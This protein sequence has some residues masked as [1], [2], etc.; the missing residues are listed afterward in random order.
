MNAQEESHGLLGSGDLVV[1]ADPSRTPVEK[2]LLLQYRAERIGKAAREWTSL[3]R[4]L[5]QLLANPLS[6]M[7]QGAL[8]ST[9]TLDHAQA[10]SDDGQPER[11]KRFLLNALKG[12]MSDLQ[13]YTDAFCSYLPL[14]LADTIIGDVPTFHSE[15][16]QLHTDIGAL[17]EDCA[18][19]TSADLHTC[20]LRRTALSFHTNNDAIIASIECLEPA[21]KIDKLY[22]CLHASGVELDELLL[23]KSAIVF[24][25][26]SVGGSSKVIKAHLACAFDVVLID[27]AAQ[28]REAETSIV[29]AG[30]PELQRLILVGDDR[31]L[32]A[33]ILSTAAMRAQ[34]GR[35]LF[36]RLHA[37]GL[38]PH[39]LATQYR[40]HPEISRW[41]TEHIYSG[42]LED[43]P[44]VKVYERPWYRMPL[45]QPMVF[46]DVQGSY[47]ETD[48]LGS[49]F[50]MAQ[51]DI[52]LSLLQELHSP[53]HA[54]PMQ[55]ITIGV[56]AP[57][58]AQ[59]TLMQRRV[60]SSEFEADIE[61]KSVDGFQGREKDIIIFSTVRAN[62][63]HSIG[64]LK[65]PNRMNVAITRPRYT[66]IV[67]GEAS[68]LSQ[69]AGNELWRSLIKDV[70]QRGGLI[71][72]QD[73]VKMRN[74]I[75]RRSLAA[76]HMQ[77]LADPSKDVFRDAPWKVH[78][79]NQF[80]AEFLALSVDLR[81]KVMRKILLLADGY[82]E[83]RHPGS[84]LAAEKGH[85]DA[86]EDS[87]AV[88]QRG[89]LNVYS[90]EQARLVWQ[91]DISAGTQ[92][93]K[94]WGVVHHTK[95]AELTRRLMQRFQQMNAEYLQD[96]VRS[97]QIA[98][99]D[100]KSHARIFPVRVGFPGYAR[101]ERCADVA[102]SSPDLPLEPAAGSVA[103][104]AGSCKME[105]SALLM[106]FYGM[107]SEVARALLTED[108]E[109]A[110]SLNLPFVVS[111]EEEAMIAS[112]ESL[113]ILGRSG[114]GK[115]TIMIHRL[116]RL[117]DQFG[118]IQRGAA[119]GDG[120]T[121]APD[122]AVQAPGEAP[123]G[124]EGESAPT[125][126]GAAPPF[127]FRQIMLSASPK[128]CRAMRA[129]VSSL[130]AGRS[131]RRRGNGD[132][133]A[134]PTSDPR[135]GVPAGG[136]LLLSNDDEDAE[137]IAWTLLEV[138]DA[139]FPLF[140]T[141]RHFL[142]MLDGTL[143]NP[144]RPSRRPAGSDRDEARRARGY[145]ANDEWGSPDTYPI[146]GSDSDGSDSDDG[147]PGEG[148]HR[149]ARNGGGCGGSAAGAG[150]AH[151]VASSGGQASS[152]RG[153]GCGKRVMLAS[154]G[155]EVDF[156]VFESVYW[157]RFPDELRRA[158]DASAVWTEIASMIKG[159]MRAARQK[160]G[161]LSLEEYL[162]AGET[163]A[164]AGG[165][166][167]DE[168]RRREVYSAALKYERMKLERGEHDM[169]DRVWHV[170]RELE[171]S[172]YCGAALHRVYVDEVQDLSEVQL[173]LLRFV[174]PDPDGFAFAGDTAQTITQ[175]VSFRFQSLRRLF[176]DEFL[177][178][179]GV[180]DGVRPVGPLQAASL[181]AVTPER[182]APSVPPLH[183]LTH[184][185]RTHRGV[186]ALAG[187][188]VATI[189]HFFP[190][191]MDRL[192]PETSLVYGPR[193]LLLECAAGG[194]GVGGAGAGLISQLFEGSLEAEA[195]SFG[196]EQ[197]I[198]VRDAASK[199]EVVQELK[200][201]G[202]SALVLTILESKGLEFSDVLVY[203]FFAESPLGTKW[204]VMYGLMR[205]QGLAC[206][207]SAQQFDA[208]RHH[209]LCA[210]LKLLYVVCTRAKNTLLLYDAH[211]AHPHPMAAY[212]VGR[213]L[214]EAR[215]LDDSIRRLLKK[216]ST[217]EEWRAQGRRLFEEQVYDQACVCF[218][219]AGDTVNQILAEKC[220]ELQRADSDIAA[221]PASKTSGKAW[222]AWRAQYLAAAEALVGLQR[223][224]AV[225]RGARAY[226][227]A[228]AW[229]QA[230]EAFRSALAVEDALDCFY[231]A[232]LFQ[233]GLELLTARVA[234][235]RDSGAGDASP[236]LSTR[237]EGPAAVAA[238]SAD[239]VRAQETVLQLQALQNGYTERCAKHFHKAGDAERMMDFVRQLPG[240]EAKLHFL[241]RRDYLQL[242]AEILVEERRPREAAE[243]LQTLGREARAGEQY[244]RA[245]LHI[246]AAAAYLREARFQCIPV[247][248]AQPATSSIPATNAGASP[249][250][251]ETSLPQQ[252]I[253]RAPGPEAAK[254][255]KHGAASGEEERAQCAVVNMG[256]GDDGSR[257]GGI[258]DGSNTELHDALGRARGALEAA[259]GGGED[260]HRQCAVHLLE[261]RVLSERLVAP[262]DLST[263]CRSLLRLWR[264]AAEARQ[265]R[266]ML[267]VAAP[268]FE[269]LLGAAERAWDLAGLGD[270]GARD[271]DKRGLTPAW[272]LW[273]YT[274][275][276][277][278]TVQVAL[279][280]LR[281]ADGVRLG[282]HR[283]LAED[284]QMQELQQL[285][286]LFGVRPHPQSFKEQEWR[287]IVEKGGRGV[288]QLDW[289]WRVHP[290]RGGAGGTPPGQATRQPP[291][292]A[293]WVPKS[294]TEPIPK[295]PLRELRL[296]TFTQHAERA[297]RSLTSTAH[298]ACADLF[299][300]MSAKLAPRSDGK[301]NPLCA[302][303]HAALPWDA[304]SDAAAP[305]AARVNA[306]DQVRAH[307]DLHAMLAGAPGGDLG[308]LGVDPTLLG[309]VRRRV[310]N[311]ALPAAAPVAGVAWAVQLRGHPEVRAALVAQA[312]EGLAGKATTESPGSASTGGGVWD[313][314]VPE[315]ERLTAGA[316]LSAL[317]LLDLAGEGG[318]LLPPVTFG[319]LEKA[320]KADQ[321]PLRM[322]LA[323]GFAWRAA[324]AGDPQPCG[325]SGLA[326]VE[327]LSQLEQLEK[328]D[329]RPMDVLAVVEH[330]A[331]MLSAEATRLAGLCLPAALAWETLGG[332]HHAA[333]YA[334]VLR[335]SAGAPDITDRQ[336][337]ESLENLACFHVMNLIGNAHAL[338]AWFKVTK[339]SPKL[340]PAFVS[341]AISVL[342]AVAIN[343]PQKRV[344]TGIQT[345]LAKIRWDA[346]YPEL[347][348]PLV[349]LLI[350][351]FSGSKQ[352]GRS[353]R[354]T[355]PEFLLG[356]GSPLLG[357]LPTPQCEEPKWMRQMAGAV[358]RVYVKHMD[359][360]QASGNCEPVIR[361]RFEPHAGGACV[362][363][364]SLSAAVPP[365]GELASRGVA[366]LQ[367]GS[368]IALGDVAA[369]VQAWLAPRGNATRGAVAGEDDMQPATGG[370]ASCGLT[371]EQGGAAVGE[372]QCADMDATVDV[373][374]AELESE[375]RPEKH[376]E[377]L[378]GTNVKVPVCALQLPSWLVQALSVWRA[379]AQASLQ[380]LAKEMSTPLGRLQKE[381]RDTLRPGLYAEQYLEVV[382]PLIDDVDREV[383]LISHVISQM[384]R[385]KED[386]V[387]V[388][389][390]YFEKL[391]ALRDI[392]D[393][394]HSRH[395]EEDVAYL[396]KEVAAPLHEG[397]GLRQQAMELSA[398][399]AA[400]SASHELGAAAPNGA[401]ETSQGQ[402]TS[403]A[404]AAGEKKKPLSKGKKPKG[405][406]KGK[407]QQKGKKKK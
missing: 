80:R 257:G 360:T 175:G 142:N 284:A 140:V 401:G 191:S 30:R 381:A 350:R 323:R 147:D 141:Y 184:N 119:P 134:T 37:T 278:A 129:Y 301:Q 200:Q 405:T 298:G 55:G 31:Q 365:A 313:L 252:T 234:A 363:F 146:N 43:G 38:K 333:L 35:S 161:R 279:H 23:E 368:G 4:G 195:G 367:G 110:A 357:I 19:Q 164:A 222:E 216:H 382:C 167:W 136:D 203:N 118:C 223:R 343:H 404:H 256:G 273:E 53:A 160:R 107:D 177:R 122:A 196:S 275:L 206:E 291:D 54:F 18:Q 94:V 309:V 182:A 352:K 245:G 385:D 50:N 207:E 62:A 159:S 290:L 6:V 253:T 327:G 9:Q 294:E 329:V 60:A 137:E 153:M 315:L 403:A 98:S 342:V 176:H 260:D 185:F 120:S 87:R 387:D 269:G 289:R 277:C 397:L 392:A 302:P 318:A 71:R 264:E 337:W 266:L 78:F 8:S 91:V 243:L 72:A 68:T 205:H 79:S 286:E 225:L 351:T 221:A 374:V 345:S 364:S 280:A 307:L 366:L 220:L 163:R 201:A 281:Q 158:M 2:E 340:L 325:Q 64:F 51:V 84:Q 58:S 306:A 123:G 39:L 384:H 27:E 355:A 395:T 210:E 330:T 96:C 305:G 254:G 321:P 45:F 398:L 133:S 353:L 268:L 42:A 388:V 262:G 331:V 32:P 97:Q 255:A 208:A 287:C 198:I 247:G 270:L 26:I 70:E 197:V 130:L 285:Q 144:F 178:N 131:T 311:L 166:A 406:A 251:K 22:K 74:L 314:P 95:Q 296:T 339:V 14:P 165:G 125:E 151:G 369:A 373:R 148:A 109:T 359:F 276:L 226:K 249:I 48:S 7:E 180:A 297:L 347:P 396:M 156:Q 152:G 138:P 157:P 52:V 271:G 320:F 150:R 394:R 189:L 349:E 115:T 383:R 341:R 299:V 232:R 267:M 16:K 81:K 99:G 106:K 29:L 231:R 100:K 82:R 47:E 143:D 213:G 135:G 46:L 371:T 370:E 214:V 63:S 75:T 77:A 102:G 316:T 228:E 310:L 218:E 335:A 211:A 293:P 25:T 322:T 116:L 312:R 186:V 376:T 104:G 261:E 375:D 328:W 209:Q 17:A 246:A 317:R 155:A 56:I 217:P 356:L 33:T 113:F 65:N 127:V 372:E 114:T 303:L 92:V 389:M 212:W 379:K 230:A 239:S 361:F 332:P 1:V 390:D 344:S 334:P 391:R 49:K 172:G 59:V 378:G 215:V 173:A 288:A 105:E 117:Q 393:V 283:R 12:R 169:A 272:Q 111:D 41:P 193:P 192:R 108:C 170:H 386:E 362:P 88:A 128:L 224:D 190:S 377:R 13:A 132:R 244:E 240:L 149:S 3:M 235:L 183:E 86:M 258:V 304:A 36:A 121:S 112:N 57:Y 241:R 93:L 237:V 348:L 126:A 202:S 154:G 67:V 69:G 402:S 76:R 259:A 263:A 83:H 319:Q 15:A 295:L 399:V 21:A 10:G 44:N 248:R 282:P 336:C 124:A 338:K 380:R 85:A 300:R 89:L 204:R 145:D 168:S 90:V 20:C 346:A 61:V 233:K 308:S 199:R 179:A 324:A 11:F 34:Y 171:R 229:E 274:R 174:C 354:Q 73:T 236:P 242:T 358:E 187:S 162:H 400:H 407:K 103:A 227:A 139:S 40:M 326:L 219:R 24:S 238:E 5:S 265:L 66:L 28:L 194:P 181:R 250:T 292:P 101:W 188:I